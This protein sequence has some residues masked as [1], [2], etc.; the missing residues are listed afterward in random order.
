VKAISMVSNQQFRTCVARTLK[1]KRGDQHLKKTR[2]GFIAESAGC[3]FVADFQTAFGRCTVNL[4]L[5]WSEIPPLTF[6][7]WEGK[8][9]IEFLDCLLS[10]RIGQFANPPVDEWWPYGD[11][12]GECMA[13]L[14]VIFDRIFCIFRNAERRW[15]SSKDF[16]IT[17]P[18]RLFDL[19]SL[20]A[21]GYIDD[22]LITT[23]I[24]PWNTTYFG[25]MLGLAHIAT[26]WNAPLL[27]R[28]FVNACKNYHY[29]IRKERPNIILDRHVQAVVDVEQII[30]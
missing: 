18:P 8:E 11:T 22:P 21:S 6:G 15:P 14:E 9:P 10:A 5:L 26:R 3:F 19:A 16:L 2:S 7:Q 30:N 28:K 29:L 17:F 25:M 4:G 1:G 20:P 23:H 24:D 12:R 13:T 27:A